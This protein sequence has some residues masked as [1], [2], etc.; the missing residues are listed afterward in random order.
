MIFNLLFI[1][2][3]NYIAN[4]YSIFF[5]SLGY[6]WNKMDPPLLLKA[7]VPDKPTGHKETTSIETYHE[8][9]DLIELL[10]D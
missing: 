1:Y 5:C 8:T 6:L 10:Y 4:S 9:L 2:N 7:I 3:Y